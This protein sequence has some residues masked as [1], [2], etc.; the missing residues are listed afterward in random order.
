VDPKAEKAFNLTPYR[1]DFNNP[2][3]FLD[4]SGTYEIDGHFWTVYLMA[5]LM[6]NKNAFNI[7]YDTEAPDNIMSRQGDIISLPSTWLNPHLQRHI[8]AL[9]G[10]SSAQTRSHAMNWV[11]YS[12]NDLGHALHY[13]GYS[14]AHSIMGN[15]AK[16]YPNG[17]GHVF[18]GHDPDKIALRPELYREYTRSLAAVLSSKFG[19]LESID[20][21]TFDYVAGS[22]GSTE[23]N[24]A[25]LEAEVRIREG[26]LSFSI[27]GNHVKALGDYLRS[28]NK[29]FG[30]NVGAIINYVDVDM[31][32]KIKMANG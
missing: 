29:H 8:H 30:R 13:L 20:M 15:E 14:Y 17:R 9:N 2:I 24:S 32:K 16:M 26:A 10:G 18:D 31:Y 27:E 23:Q 22:G 3:R 11:G 12:T 5:T 28:S 19:F 21:Y 25:I 1:Y 4:P 7:A 6:G